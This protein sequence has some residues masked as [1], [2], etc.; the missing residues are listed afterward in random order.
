MQQSDPNNMLAVLQQMDERMKGM[1]ERMKRMEERQMQ[2]ENAAATAR[3]VRA[4]AY[5]LAEAGNT[6]EAVQRMAQAARAAETTGD[7]IKG[8][9]TVGCLIGDYRGETRN[10]H[11]CGEPHGLGV[12][13]R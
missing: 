5:R 10:G 4:I 13:M 2:R 11:P 12:F 6:K 7:L 3:E 8:F 1:D 9:M